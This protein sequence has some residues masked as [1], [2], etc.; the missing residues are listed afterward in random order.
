MMKSILLYAH[1][2][3]GMES[4]MQAAL[5]IARLFDGH[6][7][8]VTVQPL[9]ALM[10]SDPFG[11][12]FVIPA[13][14][15]AMDDAA[16]AAQARLGARMAKEDVAWSLSEGDGDA[17]EIIGSQARLA[18]IV[19]LSL[20]DNSIDGSAAP[21]LLGDIVMESHVPVLAVPP[22]LDR[23]RISGIAVVA[24]NGTHEAANAMRAAIPLLAK[25][26]A[27][28][29]VTIDEGEP[30]FS[31]EAAAAYLS[32][33]GIKAEIHAEDRS[34]RSIPEALFETVERIGADWMVMGAFGKGRLR[35]ML[36]GGVTRD[37]LGRSR[38][39]IFITH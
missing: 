11:A 23:T 27:V 1:D 30:D 25:A 39:P 13:A 7:E 5:D 8:C 28:H 12:S 16:E 35:E 37:F 26:S 18:D 22:G 33:H 19:L 6:V 31:A 29:V 9:T 4:R 38:I 21:L 32:R 24:W 2:D 15:E 17:A 34:G 14:M 10:M 36:F 20:G 3:A